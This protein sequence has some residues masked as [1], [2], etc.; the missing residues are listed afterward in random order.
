M[1]SNY[2]SSSVALA[3]LK[4]R[5]TFKGAP[6][7]YPRPTDVAGMLTL[8]DTR[9]GVTAA[10]RRKNTPADQ[11]MRRT[12]QDLVA[13]IDPNVKVEP[14]VEDVSLIILLCSVSN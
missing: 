3:N 9:T 4:S 11:S 1:V 10:G 2:P 5:A 12:I 14:D 8:D 6:P 7:Q 13:S